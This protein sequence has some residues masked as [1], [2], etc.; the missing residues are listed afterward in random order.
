MKAI[1]IPHSY[2][3]FLFNVGYTLGKYDEFLI[4]ASGKEPSE[5][6]A[7]EKLMAF[8]DTD[9]PIVA[10]RTY[11]S[12]ADGTARVIYAPSTS[13]TENLVSRE[14]IVSVVA[15]FEQ[16]IPSGTNLPADNQVWPLKTT[17]LSVRHT[18]FTR[19]CG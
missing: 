4:F 8:F 11:G 16:A 9:Q 7:D 12:F 17:I 2:Q 3:H 1:V 18:L 15:F 10:G 14:A 19:L 6:F 13:H 5:L